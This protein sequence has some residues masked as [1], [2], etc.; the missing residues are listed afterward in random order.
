MAEFDEQIQ[1]EPTESVASAL[2]RAET[3]Q[4]EEQSLPSQ[5]P[6]PLDVVVAPEMTE[7]ASKKSGM[8]A[9]AKG[10]IAAGIGIVLVALVLV[11]LL[12]VVPNFGN[13]SVD[14]EDSGAPQSSGASENNEQP[15]QLTMQITQVSNDGFPTVDLYISILDTS[16][17]PVEDFA[18]DGLTVT[19]FVEG[20][21]YT[22]TVDSLLPLSSSDAM[23]ISLVLDQSGSMSDEGKMSDAK[24]AANSFVEKIADSANNSVAIMSFDDY[25]YN[26]LN[27]SADKAAMIDAINGISPDGGTA[28]YDALFSALQKTNQEDGSRYVIAF[29]DG[30]ENASTHTHDQV[31]E[32]SRLTGIPVYLV[33][34]GDDI[35]SVALSRLA[36]DCR[37]QYFS[38]NVNDMREQLLEMYDQIYQEQRSM[39]RLTYTS[40]CEDNG[41]S[42]RSIELA[43]PDGAG[44]SGKT[45]TS[46][47]PH[48][49]PIEKVDIN[50]IEKIIADSGV[51]NIGV[52]AIDATSATTIKTGSG[53]D[54]LRASALISIPIMI[55]IESDVREGTLSL[56]DTVV[57][58]HTVGGRGELKAE[59]DGERMQI[60]TLV[61]YMLRHS[62]NNAINTL[63][64]N[65]GISHINDTCK[66]LGYT[67]VR[68]ERPITLQSDSRDNY[69]SAN[70]LVLMYK[71]LYFDSTV[72][73]QAFMDSNFT[74]QDSAARRGLGKYLP[75]QYQFLNFNGVAED[76]Y[77]ELAMI[78]DGTNTY[79]VAFLGNDARQEELAES[80]ANIGSYI[81]ECLSSD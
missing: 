26:Q 2:P 21:S 71:Q 33:G 76:K 38:V 17:N 29:T 35:D 27:F 28:L 78:S 24:F 64:D 16:G 7:N 40:S 37:G 20:V 41:Y 22:A 14:N 80:A 48:D 52:A 73:G 74:I 55:T 50:A 5:E 57:F 49:S 32:L 31:A 44:Y 61:E 53:N 42:Y 43:C 15:E 4:V 3:S 18:S 65:L 10:G 11:V 79:V 12:V 13:L 75:E 59:Q 63:I 60:R 70:D 34:V 6:D 66:R 77:T 9:V 36:T 19:E 69:I 45:E 30:M 68:M 72:F 67:S 23:S 47:V 58:R 51:G 8:S 54:A 81:G 56:D 1:V 39:Y 25:V 62:D 46:Y